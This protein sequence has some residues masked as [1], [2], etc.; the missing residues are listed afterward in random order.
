M[1][2][3]K[4]KI[5]ALGRCDCREKGR[6]ESQALVSGSITHLLNKHKHLHGT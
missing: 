1:T 2:E 5:S 3:A 4:R 6:G